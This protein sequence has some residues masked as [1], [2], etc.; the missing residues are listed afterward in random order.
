MKRIA[1]PSKGT[2]STTPLSVNQLDLPHFGALATRPRVTVVGRLYDKSS[3]IVEMRRDDT[4]RAVAA[5]A[6]TS[7]PVAGQPRAVAPAQHTVSSA[8]TRPAPIISPQRVVTPAPQ[9][10]EP[11]EDKTP[12]VAGPP[13]DKI[14]RVVL[15]GC[16]KKKL[17]GSHAARDLYQGALF[18][19]A[20]AHAERVGDETFVVSAFHGLVPLDR[21]LDNYDRTLRTAIERESW[22]YRVCS[23]LRGRMKRRRYAVT[24][25]AGETYAE[26]LR[27]YLQI[28]N[29]DDL[30]VCTPLAGLSLGFQLRWFR[31]A[32]DLAGAQ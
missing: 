23:D 25:L 8:V 31:I 13:A 32:A 21:E 22:A 28:L 11:A 16:S 19:A 29:G 6:D 24:I 10:V 9:T 12:R 26:P 1:S 2:L 17:D 27:K 5:T 4:T 30:E 14:V 3:P 15:V 18:K 7:A 20:L